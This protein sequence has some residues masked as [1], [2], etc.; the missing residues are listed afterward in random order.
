V[1]IFINGW[2]GKFGAVDAARLEVASVPF[3]AGA[4]IKDLACKM[5]FIDLTK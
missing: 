5:L 3:V 2:Q 4:S 1:G